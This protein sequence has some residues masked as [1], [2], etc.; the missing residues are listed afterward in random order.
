MNNN[1]PTPDELQKSWE[2]LGNIYVQHLEQH[3]VKLPN[4]RRYNE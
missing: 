2:D 1:L 4:V 3:E